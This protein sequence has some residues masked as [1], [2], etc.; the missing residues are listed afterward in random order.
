MSDGRIPRSA[1]PLSRA[2][3]GGAATGGGGLLRRSLDRAPAPDATVLIRGAQLLDPRAGL[4]Q[5]GDL[6]VREG[7][8]AG[9]GAPGSLTA[10]EG[11]AL[12][13]P[14]RPHRQAAR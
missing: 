10:P 11:A 1:D 8:I 13:A 14:P 7:G 6:L 12:G 9:I 2:A 4:D 3:A 5:P